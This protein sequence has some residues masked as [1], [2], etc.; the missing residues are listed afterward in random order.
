MGGWLSVVECGL[1]LR[2]GFRLR[3]SAVVVIDAAV[4]DGQFSLAAVAF[5]IKVGVLTLGLD[6]VSHG[7]ERRFRV[8]AVTPASRVGSLLLITPGVRR[9]LPLSALLLSLL[10]A[11]G[12]DANVA[13]IDLQ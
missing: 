2:E 9:C 3:W 8:G 10:R 6:D 1:Y 12:D 7:L 5:R 11:A 13:G 4:G